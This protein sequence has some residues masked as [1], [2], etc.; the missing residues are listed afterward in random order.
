MLI[1]IETKYEE[2]TSKRNG[3]SLTERQHSERYTVVSNMR[4]D[5]FAGFVSLGCFWAFVS[6][7]SGRF[8]S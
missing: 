1:N 8:G 7:G 2:I 3:S 5:F 4:R 6:F